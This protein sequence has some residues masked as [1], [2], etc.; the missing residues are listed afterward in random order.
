MNEYTRNF[1]HVL[2]SGPAAIAQV[3]ESIIGKECYNSLAL[4]F[5]YRDVPCLKLALSKGLGYGI[6]AGGCIVKIPQILKVLY[7]SSAVGLSLSSVLLETAA[8]AIS[9]AYNVRSGNPFST[10]GETFFIVLQNF[11]LLMLILYYNRRPASL[12]LVTLLNAAGLYAL[13][14]PDI[15]DK[16]YLVYLQASTIPITV[17]SKIP[18]IMVNF[19]NKSTGQL[20]A[21]ATFN[22][23]FGSA[24]RVYTTQQ[25]VKD[26]LIFSGFLLAA[27]FNFILVVQMLW[28]VCESLLN[29][30]YDR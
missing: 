10:Y 19:V 8:Y 12:V 6:V 27:V 13:L 5:N 23:F 11:I 26:P 20:S 4:N 1:L 7:N 2:T 29:A 16:S 24:A 25:E 15:V 3:G 30:V 21:F 28:L 22:Y 17:L 9:L 14:T 18:Q